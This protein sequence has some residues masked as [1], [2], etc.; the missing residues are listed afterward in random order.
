MM[1][2][3]NI[4]MALRN[5]RSRQMR[6]WLTI[7]GIIVS[8]GAII[9]LVALSNGLELAIVKMFDKMGSQRVMVM[10]IGM[11]SGSTAI[12]FGENDLD[13]IS[14]VNGVDYA[15]PYYVKYGVE[16][17]YKG[18]KISVI[19]SGVPSESGD[20]MLELYDYEIYSGRFLEKGD[21]YKIVVGY[22]YKEDLFEKSLDVKNSIKINGEKFEVVGIMEEFGNSQDDSSILLPI[23]NAWDLLNDGAKD[24]HYVDVGIKDGFN[25]SLVGDKIE[26]R[27]E[28]Y[29]G[30]KD[31][32]IVTP[33]QML[34]QFQ[35]TLGVVKVILVSVALISLL[36]GAVG[37]MNSMYTSVI[38]RTP[39]IGI[40]KSVGA[41]NTDILSIFV[42]EA[43]IIGLI[44]GVFG[45]S[46]GTAA[47]YLVGY[48]AEMSGFKLLE[49]TVDPVLIF[50]GIMFAVIVGIASGAVPAWQAS[51]LKPV[52]ALRY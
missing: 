38:E 50:G 37:I 44:G 30:E 14:G 51:K 1:G 4:K 43:G 46:L 15:L 25:I 6:S 3:D 32:N 29:R 16:I 21:Q 18:E 9:T 49:I 40:M 39:E 10:P 36:V 41:S 26:T 7:I 35:V 19:M 31:F 33:E 28:R 45:V 52:D 12:S 22:L 34:E 47:S 24:I 42:S 27:L 48:I 23:D 20:L 13:I 11:Q 8:V 2:S 5:I 17:E